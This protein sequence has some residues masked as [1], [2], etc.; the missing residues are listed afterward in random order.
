MAAI[1]LGIEPEY[2]EITQRKKGSVVRKHTESGAVEVDVAGKAE[3]LLSNVSENSELGNAAVLHLNLSAAVKFGLVTIRSESQRI[4]VSNRRK[5]TKLALEAH[6][7]SRVSGAHA[8]CRGEGSY[9]EEG[10]EDGKGLEHLWGLVCGGSSERGSWWES[11]RRHFEDPQPGRYP[12]P[13]YIGAYIWDRKGFGST[14][15]PG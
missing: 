13:V 14:H 15:P 7:Q 2:I 6:L 5:S 9:A 11:T 1:P 3:V 10:G 4:P 12:E 8:S